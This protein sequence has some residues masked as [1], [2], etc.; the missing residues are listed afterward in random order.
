M[1]EKQI[2]VWT[3]FYGHYDGSAEIKMET[4]GS[5]MD[6]IYKEYPL[7]GRIKLAFN[8]IPKKA[9]TLLDGGC[10]WGYG[11]RFFQEKCRQAHGIDTNE[12]AIAVARRRY[13]HIRFEKCALE[14]TPYKANHFDVIILNDVLEHVGDEI[15]SLNETHRILKPHGAL[16]IT[17]PHKGILSF[18]DIANYGYFLQKSWPY[19]YRRY[20][21]IQNGKHAPRREKTRHRHYSRADIIKLLDASNF[22]QGYVIEKTFRS[23]LGWGMVHEN[24]IFFLKFILGPRITS[25]LLTPLFLLADWDYWIPYSGFSY[26]IAL[27]ILKT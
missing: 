21:R 15:K 9:D 16:I 17:V 8:W 7:N 22:H 19:A 5:K 3:Q 27:K 1:V 12:K 18:M 23:G 4:T 24:L 25:M 13:P 10:S 14:H 2:C 11:T 20:Y 26:H 6:D